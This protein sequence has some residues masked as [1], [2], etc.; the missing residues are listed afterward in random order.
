MR[1][2]SADP[3]LEIGHSPLRQV[4]GAFRPQIGTPGG[5]S[6]PTPPRLVSVVDTPTLT[7]LSW[8]LAMLSRSQEAPPSWTQEQTE[9]E[10]R[11]LLLRWSPDLVTFQELP[12]V[13]PYV[14]THDMVRANPRSHSGNLATLVG[15]HLIDGSDW[16][17]HAGLPTPI[18]V[19]GCGLLVAF[20]DLDLSVANVHL[21]PGRGAAGT[22]MA[23][24]QAVSSRAPT[25][26]VVIVG[27][28]NIRVAEEPAIESLGLQAPRPPR[29][30][31]D[32]R[33]NRFHGPDGEFVANFTR[34]LATPGVRVT[35][36][37][38]RSGG[39]T[40]DGHAFHLSD[41]FALEVTIGLNPG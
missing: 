23:Q 22:R 12:G 10:V 30:T 16:G 31:W 6:R 34:V 18:V 28:T 36:Q 26:D 41:H 4:S 3:G 7:I 15:N 2:Q 29:P 39:L 14:E 5:G 32:G 1:R 25:S 37:I 40:I 21:A 9:A 11:D 35:E 27:D 33:R 19:D 13:V 20:A 38:V 8:N 17:D 24:L